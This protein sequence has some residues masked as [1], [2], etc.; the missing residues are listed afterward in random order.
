MPICRESCKVCQDLKSEFS[1][2]PTRLYGNEYFSA[3]LEDNQ[4]SFTR[5]IPYERQKDST[6]DVQQN[7]QLL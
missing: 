7:L 2:R 5:N 1:K 4:S 6:D 3:N